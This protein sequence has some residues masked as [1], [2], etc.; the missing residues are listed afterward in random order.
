MSSWQQYLSDNQSRFVDEMLEFLS[1]PSVSSLPEHAAD[2]QTAGEWVAAR[3]KQAGIE[4]V[5]IMPTGGH[6]VVY[7][8]WLHAAGKPTVLIYGHFDTQPVDPEAL[9]KTP[10]FTP[11]IDGD[12]IYARRVG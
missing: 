11:T 12:R 3:M 7:G 10:P 9:W 5:E 8:D 6:P 1:I 2:V 4:N